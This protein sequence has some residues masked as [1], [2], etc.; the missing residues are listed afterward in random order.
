M[1]EKIQSFA[2]DGAGDFALV[3]AQEVKILTDGSGLVFQHL[4]VINKNGVDTYFKQCIFT[5]AI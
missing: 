4:L 2:G 3:V 5:V 1:V